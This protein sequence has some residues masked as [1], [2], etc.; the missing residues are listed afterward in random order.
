MKDKPFILLFCFLASL[1]FSVLFFFFPPWLK[2]ILPQSKHS[3]GPFLDTVTLLRCYGIGSNHIQT[4]DYLYN[5]DYKNTSK[6][7][8]CSDVLRADENEVKS[9]S[10]F[11]LHLKDGTT[12]VLSTVK[13]Q[14]TPSKH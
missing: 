6:I 2:I 13:K 1:N 3:S 14:E 11:F 7:R 10:M 9:T 5:V 8:F 4:N 12:C